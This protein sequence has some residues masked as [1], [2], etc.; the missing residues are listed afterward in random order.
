LAET[1]YQYWYENT[2]EMDDSLNRMAVSFWRRST[3]ARTASTGSLLSAVRK[4]LIDPSWLQVRIAPN[5]FVASFSQM[6]MS[7]SVSVSRL[8]NG[9][10]VHTVE[11]EAFT[12]V[13]K[14]TVAQADLLQ[15]LDFLDLML[16]VGLKIASRDRHQLTMMELS[17]HDFAVVLMVAT[18]MAS[19]LGSMASLVL[20]IVERGWV[21]KC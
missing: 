4:S 14:A 19:S 17:S 10:N 2:K 21:V 20:L 8:M 13:D 16:L 6:A 5:C 1:R 9:S 12:A 18:D 11:L 7:V 15:R 3:R